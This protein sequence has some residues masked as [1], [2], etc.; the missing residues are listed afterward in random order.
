L[1]DR[2]YTTGEDSLSRRSAQTALWHITAS[3]LRVMAPFLSFTAEE[4]QQIFKPGSQTIFTE[5]YHVFPAVRD[6]NL[7]LAKWSQIREVRAEVL[8][9]IETLRADG[10]VGSSL[11]AEVDLTIAGEMFQVLRSLGDDL[12]FITI[13]SRC[14]LHEGDFAVQVKASTHKKCE[15]CWHYRDDVGSHDEHPEICGRCVSNLLG[16]G[17]KRTIA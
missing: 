7:L 17:E 4:A 1:K 16:S 10:K 2:L 8:K 5:T 3:L 11:Q 9:A 12:K 6:A 13:T 14:T 15:R